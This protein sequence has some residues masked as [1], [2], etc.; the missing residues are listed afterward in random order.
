VEEKE[1][2]IKDYVEIVEI[3]S[4]TTLKCMGNDFNKETIFMWY[5]GSQILAQGKQ[6]FGDKE[7]IAFDQTSGTLTIKGIQVSDDGKYRCRAF[8]KNRY[9]TNIELQVNGPPSHIA[10]G[11]NQGNKEDI[12]NLKISYKVGEKDLRF[13][14]NPSTSR[15]SAKVTWNHNGN[16]I[17]ASKDHDISIDGSLLFFKTLHAKHAGRYECDASNDHGN[18]K[19]HFDLDV[20]CKWIVVMTCSRDGHFF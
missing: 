1:Y 4:S 19:A 16:V 18:I 10:I 12:S 3:D 11:H 7:R 17:E 6:Q 2:I 9:E 13:K 8:A 14:C 20:Q 5:N 15:P